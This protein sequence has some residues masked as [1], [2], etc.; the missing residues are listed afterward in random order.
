ML[1]KLVAV[2][3][4]PKYL[5]HCCCNGSA[6]MT[7]ASFENI[8]VFIL[9]AS[10]HQCLYCCSGIHFDTYKHLYKF[11]VFSR[12]W[13][14]T[15][16]SFTRADQ[17]PDDDQLDSDEEYMF[18]LRQQQQSLHPNHVD[19]QRV[20]EI[21]AKEPKPNAVPLKSALKKKPGQTSTSSPATPTQDHSNANGNVQQGG[22][23]GGGAATSASQRPL[24]VRQ[25]A[26][27]SYSLK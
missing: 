6:L 13:H 18:Q 19:T 4:I 17:E 15:F 24:V 22:G 26:T 12:I 9:N 25:D 27:N 7:T 14:S 20:E 1:I 21:P 2:I 10:H 3:T 8:I 23:G 11:I 16:N 5:G